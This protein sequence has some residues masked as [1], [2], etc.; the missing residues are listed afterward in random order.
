M[1]SSRYF[2]LLLLF[3][4]FLQASFS[5]SVFSADL[6]VMDT[7]AILGFYDPY[8]AELFG[9]TR[10]SFAVSGGVRNYDFNGP[11]GR[12]NFH[13]SYA[14]ACLTIYG[15]TFSASYPQ[16]GDRITRGGLF[17]DDG[18]FL[19]AG[20][21]ASH[22]NARIG[23]S[24]TVPFGFETKSE[25]VSLNAGFATKINEYIMPFISMKN[26]ISN[27]YTPIMDDVSFFTSSGW[28]FTADAGIFFTPF[29]SLSFS[30]KG[31]NLLSQEQ[32]IPLGLF[33]LPVE[34]RPGLSADIFYRAF[35]W[36]EIS[37]GISGSEKATKID[38]P[39]FI[40]RYSSRLEYRA[41][42]TF[43]AGD[44]TVRLGASGDSRPVS[45]MPM[46]TFTAG[47]YF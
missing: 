7:S 36:L 5:V 43:I 10:N 4:A 1:N 27:G 8:N 21:R 13:M 38:V 46:I 20:F 17:T 18:F 40:V 26:V 41:G 12:E 16:F 44:T 32:L 24:I 37:A 14:S 6:P 22:L 42:I 11:A 3:V 34:F 45:G 29:E 33:A 28:P 25:G 39:D 35:E 2:K 9:T 30:V 19:T 15:I 23:A 47:Q 31:T